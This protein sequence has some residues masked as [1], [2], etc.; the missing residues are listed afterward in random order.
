MLLY[1]IYLRISQY[2]ITMNRYFVV[3]F[4][5]WLLIISIY[6]VFSKKKSLSMITVSLTLISF[7]ISIGPWSVFSLPLERQYNRLIK[8]LET[9]QILDNQNIIPLKS[10]QDINKE[11]SN[12]IYS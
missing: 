1:A 9:A 12:D 4:G 11:L 6:F 3:I 2:D 7:I 10:P 5:I 8:N